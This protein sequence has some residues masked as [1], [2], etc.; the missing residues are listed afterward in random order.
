MG[1]QGL[2][3]FLNSASMSVNIDELTNCVALV[4]IYC[5]L[6]K[7][8]YGC[9]DDIFNKKD[10][11]YYVDYCLYK[12]ESL[13]KIGIKCILVFDGLN[14]PSKKVTEDARRRNREKTKEKVKQLILE[15]NKKEASEMMKRCIDITPEMAKKLINACRQRG[16]DYIVAPYE[17]DAQI[18]YLMRKK[19]GHFV[20]TE[21]S[22]LLLFECDYVLVKFDKFGKGVLIR[23]S[24]ISDC[25]GPKARNFTFE[26]FRRMCILSGCD[27]LPSLPGIG[28]QKAK[29]FFGV[30][31]NEDMRKALPKLPSYLKMKGLKVDKEY[32]E[33]FLRAENTF[34]YQIV[35][36]PFERKLVPLNPYDDN[37][38][39][40]DL[41]Y[42]GKRFDDNL[43]LQ[44]ALGNVDVKTMKVIDSYVP[45]NF[46]YSNSEKDD[47]IWSI[48]F[49]PREFNPLELRFS[50]KSNVSELNSTQLSQEDSFISQSPT[51]SQKRSS[52]E[53]TPSAKRMNID[54]SLIDSY[55]QLKQEEADDISIVK[56]RHFSSQEEEDDLANK[57]FD[58]IVE[59]RD[60]RRKKLSFLC[61]FNA[62]YFE[63]V[64]VE[65]NK[66]VT[67]PTAPTPPNSQPSIS[68]SQSSVNS[69]SECS[70]LSTLSSQSS[71]S[72]QSSS[73]SSSQ[74]LTSS[75]ELAEPIIKV[76][77]PQEKKPETK[78]IQNSISLLERFAFKKRPLSKT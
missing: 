30:T 45:A 27:Y 56:S 66:V 74:P 61:S 44:W 62:S 28:L 39:P 57:T 60:K 50:R 35:F 37:V 23:R 13:K 10:T 78:S 71:Q 14:L 68:S 22:D 46:K 51:L 20:I 43:A 8:V 76:T 16:I 29:K 77:P 69:S 48:N 34:K 9:S 4:D 26:K 1:I 17:A 70:T 12:V 24:K 64:T 40:Q 38:N 31:M 5:W 6:H 65:D 73:Q 19:V 21:D 47:S 53:P 15:G 3:P 25:L 36:C 63:D 7:A 42:A 52:T 49:K 41:D 2:L 32:I 11:S 18:G 54:T 55:R 67:T 59:E 58:E 72:S 33:G 75:I